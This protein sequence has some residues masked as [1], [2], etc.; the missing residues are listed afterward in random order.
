MKY[1]LSSDF[2]L[3]NLLAIGFALAVAFQAG[4]SAARGWAISSIGATTGAQWATNLFGHL[5]R[6]PLEFFE[7]RRTGDL[8]SAF[9]FAAS[10]PA[11]LDRK[12]RRDPAR[13]RDGSAHAGAHRNL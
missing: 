7:K 5:L 3:L 2:G 12:F 8:L 1:W 9:R 10:D 13:R 4:L 6:L 11:D